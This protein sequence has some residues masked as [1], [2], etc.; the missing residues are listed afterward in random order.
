M[1]PARTA[2][3]LNALGHD[4]LSVHDAGLAGAPDEAVYLLAFAETRVVVTENFADF[5]LLLTER[6]DRGEPCAPVVFVRKRSF[7]RAGALA[8]HLARHLDAWAGLNPEPFPGIHW[9]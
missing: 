6:T 5:A 3:E 4:A 1:L 8:I 9:P 2:A 7:P